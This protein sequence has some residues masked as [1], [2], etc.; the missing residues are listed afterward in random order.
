M[1]KILRWLVFIFI[2]SGLDYSWGQFQPTDNVPV[3]FTVPDSLTGFP[4]TPDSIFFALYSDYS[5]TIVRAQTA[6]TNWNGKVG[7]YYYDLAVPDT[8]GIYIGRIDWWDYGQTNSHIIHAPLIKVVDTSLMARTVWRGLPLNFGDSSGY[9]GFYLKQSYDSMLAE[10]TITDFIDSLIG[11]QAFWDTLALYAGGDSTIFSRWIKR[12]VWGIPSGSGGD[13]STAAQRLVALL[14]NGITSAKIADSAIDSGKFTGGTLE[15]FAQGN[16]N[17]RQRILTSTA[18]NLID[19]PSFELDSVIAGNGGYPALWTIDA[20]PTCTLKITSVPLPVL[21]MIGSGRWYAKIDGNVNGDSMALTS[22]VFNLPNSGTLAFGCKTKDYFRNDSLYLSNYKGR[23]VALS[24]YNIGTHWNVFM[25]IYNIQPDDTGSFEII[26]KMKCVG[27]GDDSYI[28]DFFAY[29]VPTGDSINIF[30]ND[31]AVLAHFI[32]VDSAKY[33]STQAIIDSLNILAAT[34]ATMGDSIKKTLDSLYALAPVV[35]RKTD[36]A[37][38]DISSNLGYADSIAAHIRTSGLT[39]DVIDSIL[40]MAVADTSNNSLLAQLVRDGASGGYGAD[41]AT[42][43]Q[44]ILHI[45]VSDTVPGSWAAKILS[46]QHCDSGYNYT[47]PNSGAPALCTV[48]LIYFRG[49]TPVQN[50]TLTIRNDNVATDTTTGLLIGPYMKT[51]QSD[52]AG[53]VVI[54]DVPKTYLFNDS[55]LGLYDISLSY[56]GRVIVSWQ[57]VF[58]PNQDTLRMTVQ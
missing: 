26:Y 11:T 4:T 2:L 23:I 33:D 39:Q 19:N 44:A 10:A 46:S 9:A 5:T 21:G 14:D 36:S 56:G 22:K 3:F 43:I 15:K 16:W 52:T 47:I 42:I 27:L 18:E 35:M 48:F 50:A 28:D 7:E 51:A 29:Y 34:L 49:A 32:T 30:A 12:L 25:G 40:A 45:L 8:V 24:D 20:S 55:T 1:V 37:L 17:W 13:S 54:I 57:D 53:L 38:I 41:T 58:I 6:M 31:K